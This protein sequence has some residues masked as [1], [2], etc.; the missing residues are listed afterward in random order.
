MKKI[1]YL[2]INL[3]VSAGLVT[4]G[5]NLVSLEDT[6]LNLIGFLIILFTTVAVI[7]FIYKIFGFDLMNWDVEEYLENKDVKQG[8]NKTETNK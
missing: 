4:F 6:F 8:E 2:I 5:M 7:Y 3:L 1:I